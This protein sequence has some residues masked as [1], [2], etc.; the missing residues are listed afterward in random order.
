M[1]DRYIYTDFGGLLRPEKR[2]FSAE[3][4]WR[5][6][7]PRACPAPVHA[8]PHQ[9]PPPPSPP[10]PT[11]RKERRRKVIPNSQETLFVPSCCRNPRGGGHVDGWMERCIYIDPFFDHSPTITR[12]QDLAPVI[13]MAGPKPQTPA[14]PTSWHR[15]RLQI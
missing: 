12:S 13:W 5:E 3:I 1:P 2:C 7:K 6:N 9:T 8:A 11:G 4:S 10:P 14:R 15:G